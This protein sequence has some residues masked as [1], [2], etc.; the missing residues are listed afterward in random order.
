M[1]AMG[2]RGGDDLFRL[3]RRHEVI[4]IPGRSA[5]PR[6]VARH[7]VVFS[8]IQERHNKSFLRYDHVVAGS[9]HKQAEDLV[10]TVDE[11]T[12]IRCAVGSGIIR[13]EV[14]MNASGTEVRYNLAFIN[15]LLFTGDN[16]RVLGYDTAHGDLHRHYA[17][18]V[19]KVEPAS[20]SDILERFIAEVGELRK[21]KKL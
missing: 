21:R 14:W 11:S 13:E 4:A 7:I 17:G 20:Y 8:S 9:K 18:T 19:T 1:R 15:H 16:G 10:K 3:R 2:F 5:R 6:E 12:V